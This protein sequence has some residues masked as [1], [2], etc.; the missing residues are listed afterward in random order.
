M[1]KNKRQG[2]LVIIVLISVLLFTKCTSN[3]VISETTKESTITTDTLLVNQFIQEMN[4]F[5]FENCKINWRF[6][7]NINIV[8]LIHTN[9]NELWCLRNYARK[10]NKIA[11]EMLTKIVIYWG[12]DQPI[13]YLNS[14]LFK[15][16]SDPELFEEFIHLLQY[17]TETEITPNYVISPIHIGISIN[18]VEPMIYSIDGILFPEYYQ[19][20]KYLRSYDVSA[21]EYYDQMLRLWKDGKIKLKEKY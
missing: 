8:N 5:E 1:D 17:Q 15:E 6:P 14:N 9:I 12:E 16:V 13:K 21:T 18:L 7:P 19:S 20:S 10:G 3:K 2:K 4:A 11:I